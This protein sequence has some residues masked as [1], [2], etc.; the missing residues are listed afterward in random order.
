MEMKMG[1]RMRTK[2]RMGVRMKRQHHGEDKMVLVVLLVA[3]WLSENCI[4]W[5]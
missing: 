2:M 4:A 3:S 5:C 1:M